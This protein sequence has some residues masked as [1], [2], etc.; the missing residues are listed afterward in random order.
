MQPPLQSGTHM[1][2]SRTRPPAS[3]P[4]ATLLEGQTLPEAEAGG[5]RKAWGWRESESVPTL[6][7]DHGH[8]ARVTGSP[9][10]ASMDIRFM[11]E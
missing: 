3:S 7:L 2:Y 1:C 6:G 9:C 5:D 8:V 10:V 4:V 11:Y